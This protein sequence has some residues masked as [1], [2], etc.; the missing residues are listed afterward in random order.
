VIIG[1]IIAQRTSFGEITGEW[2]FLRTICGLT[3]AE[4]VRRLISPKFPDVP[5]A[6]QGAILTREIGGKG[7]FG[8]FRNRLDR[9]FP[10]RTTDLKLLC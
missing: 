6:C 8:P 10:G 2:M 1:E 3:A 5:L 7:G 4:R 9:L